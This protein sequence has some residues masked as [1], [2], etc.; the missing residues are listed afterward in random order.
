MQ[1]YTDFHT[2]VLRSIYDSVIILDNVSLIY[3]E[4]EMVNSECTFSGNMLIQQS[5]HG[6]EIYLQLQI[7]GTILCDKDS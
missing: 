7:I 2:I 5:T 3:L 4:A 1:R 6:P